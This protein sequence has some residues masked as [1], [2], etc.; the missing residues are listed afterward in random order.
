VG[1]TVPDV[2]RPPLPEGASSLL[3]RHLTDD[4]YTAL[5]TRRSAAGAVLDDLIRSG[6]ENPDSAV[7]IYA[8]DADCYR[9]FAPLLDPVIAEH[10]HHAPAASHRSD[11]RA[12]GLPARDLGPAVLSTRIRAARN[13]AGFTF[14]TRIEREA[15]REA[16]AHLV[17]AL[18]TLQGDLA[19]RYVPLAALG[20]EDQARLVADHVL[21]HA[22]DRFQRAAGLMRDWPE[23]RGLYRAADS[24]LLAWVHEEDHLRVIAMQPGG[25]VAAV[26]TRLMRALHHLE[27][28]LD[29]AFDARL[30][31]LTSCP[32][33]L[34][35]A[36]NASVHVRLPHLAAHP[37]ALGALAARFDLQ[38]RGVRGEHT[39]AAEGVV[40]LCN[41]RRL[42]VTEVEC[43]RALADGV[44]AILAAEAECTP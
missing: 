23:G 29:F 14:G 32:S 1:A 40:A 21:F 13:L 16:E 12:E 41:A 11:R 3:C 6:V 22:G 43:A 36:L 5:A 38:V 27:R 35:T 26:F 4:V 31:W 2:R 33:N 39:E 24:R 28:A 7:G 15:R 30:G 34:G 44:A 18:A 9:T 8:A 10:H 37:D 19:G 42:G 20:A 25:D 17:A